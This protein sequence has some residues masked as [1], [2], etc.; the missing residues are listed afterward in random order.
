[1]NGT[2]FTT[3][4]VVTATSSLAINNG[5]TA[6]TTWYNGGVAFFNGTLGT[7]S[8][9]TL[10]RGFFWD[11][12]N[13]RLGIGTTTP[14]G[15]LTLNTTTNAANVFTINNSIGSTTFSA[16]TLDSDSPIFSVGTSTGAEY[17]E[18]A[19]GG[20]IGVGTTTPGS[21]LS[22]NNT[23]NFGPNLSSFYSTTVNV[24][25][26]SKLGLG[27]TSP[28]ALLSINATGIQN[29]PSFVIGS[30]SPNSNG[31]SFG[32]TTFVVTSGGRIG[33]GTS[34]PNSVFTLEA[35]TGTAP[36]L[37]NI[38]SSTNGLSTTT[39]L[40]VDNQGYTGIGTSTPFGLLSINPNGL[41]VGVPAFVIG[42]STGTGNGLS[43]NGTLFTVTNGGKVG[44]GTSSPNSI[45][46]MEVATGSAPFLFNISS[47]PNGTATTSR[48]VI[49]NQGFIGVGT[50]SPFATFSIEQQSGNQPVFFIGDTGTATPL[51]AVAGNGSVRIGT[52]TSIGSGTASSTLLVVGNTSVTNIVAAFGNANGT[53]FI[54]PKV[55]GTTC[56]S[57]IRLKK[58][59]TALTPALTGILSLDP[60]TYNW[61]NETTGVDAVHT[62]FIAQQVEPIFPDLIYTDDNGYKSLNYGGVTPYLVS[63]IQEVN[64]SLDISNA[65]TGT[66]TLRSF[67]AGTSTAAITIAANGNVG[68]GTTSPN[69]TLDVY[70]DVAAI[71]FVNTSTRAAKTDISYLNASSTDDILAQIQGVQIAQYRY[72][73]ESASDPLRLGLIAEQAPSQVLSLDGKGVDIYKLST[74]TL[75]GVQA[76]AK[77]VDAQ[78]MRMDSLE[79]RIKKLENGS[80][81]LSTTSPLTFSTSTLTSA[82]SDLGVLIQKGIA[83]FDTLVARQFVAATDTAGQSVAGS[84]AILTGTTTVAVQNAYA[85]P[86]SKI[87]ITPT[88]PIDG[89]WYLTHATDGSFSVN[90]SK[91]QTNDVTF[92]YFIVQT[93]GQ[94][95]SPTAATSTAPVPPTP[96]PPPPTSPPPSTTP[97][98]D[99][100]T[101]TPPDTSTSTP[102]DTD[103]STPPADSGTTTPPDVILSPPADAPPPS[104]PPPSGG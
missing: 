29:V 82:M 52:T 24:A 103:T 77:K 61:K 13:S 6:T 18:V 48:F 43:F 30:S 62:G 1:L 84:S 28:W 83:Q 59:I 44:I 36:F 75:A 88:S 91:T 5:G 99:T 74:F 100:G 46:T 16:D 65:L 11:N 23:A 92:D 22:L 32:G 78:G 93:E 25:S 4:G 47:S 20:N 7:L 35:A 8:Q 89:S 3:N 81:A 85:H 80:I 98:P 72:K 49:D 71:S 68:I 38:S 56:S 102:P 104:D 87:L 26:T 76:L 57:D 73:M 96:T 19:A 34:T 70:G 64:G 53:C 101:T 50:S 66:S 31:T 40:V 58:N 51:F 54:S 41:R 14:L 79:D 60:V 97:P 95:A 86:T 55:A 15:L 12:T 94:L 17:F 45:F 69:H 27:S 9:A 37:F 33:I 63:A 2:L 90:L 39:N 21:L 42:S 67:Y 10:Q